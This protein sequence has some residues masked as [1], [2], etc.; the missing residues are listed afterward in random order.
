MKGLIDNFSF[1]EIIVFIIF[2]AAAIKGAIDF[3]DW[4]KNRLKEAFDKE[5]NAE[6]QQIDINNKFE[7]YEERIEQLEES[8]SKIL[9]I[10]NEM[11]IKV[12]MLIDSDKD[13]IKSFIT[14][15]HHFYCYTQGWIDDYSLECCERRY[16]HY[17]DEGGNSFIASFM[18]E[19]RAL[20]KHPPK[21]TNTTEDNNTIVG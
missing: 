7:K 11:H 10:L 15:E 6:E 19:L 5:H 1:Y 9:D 3:Y 13:D 18:K 17:V 21:N 2:F 12:N 8:Q 4:G 16:A 14:R 20:P